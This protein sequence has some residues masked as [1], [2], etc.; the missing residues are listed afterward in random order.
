MCANNLV[1]KGKNKE[2]KETGDSRYFYQN[3]LDQVRCQHYLI[4]GAYQHFAKREVPSNVLCNKA[5]K[6]ASS[7]K[8]D[9]YQG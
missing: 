6:I 1:T 9:G 5:I 7:P 4:Y 8:K 3:E 2:S